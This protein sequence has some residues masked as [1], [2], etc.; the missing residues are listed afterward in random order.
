MD[1]ADSDAAQIMHT[2]PTIPRYYCAIFWMDAVVPFCFSV[3]GIR[4]GGDVPE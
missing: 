2:V 3:L 1:D 4:V